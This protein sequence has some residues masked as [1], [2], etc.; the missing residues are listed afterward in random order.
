[1]N[2]T[3]KI[4]ISIL[5]FT[6]IYGQTVYEEILYENGQEIDTFA[7]QLPENFNPDNIYPLLIAFHQWGGNHL[8][9]F[10]TTFDE[11]ANSRNWIFMSPFGGSSNNYNH[12]EAQEMVKKAIEWLMDNYHIDKN[13]IYAVGGSMGGAS[14][15]IYANN[16]LNPNEPMIAATA[17]ASGIL[18]CERRAIEMDG[19]NSMTEWFGGNYDEVPFE[20]HRNSA[21]YFADST[22]SMHY[23]LKYIPLYFDFGITETH[24][25]HAEEMYQI[26]SGYNNNMWIDQEPTGSH[27]FSVFDEN[28]VCDWLSQFELIDNPDTIN[29]NLDQSSRAYWLEVNNEEQIENEFMRITASREIYQDSLVINIEQTYN[30]TN[31]N[32]TLHVMDNLYNYINLY[33]EGVSSNE[34]NSIGLTGELI[35]YVSHI[36]VNGCD[37]CITMEEDIIWVVINAENNLLTIHYPS[38][39]N[40]DGSWDILDILLTINFIMNQIEPTPEQNFLA[41]MNQDGIINILDI[42]SMVNL[43]LNQ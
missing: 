22:Q 3:I 28:H 27:G 6:Q 38:D 42:I 2:W 36:S 23:N 21:I 13:R 7:Y 29:V 4:L 20:Y 37:F 31:N 43:I 35:N 11:E 17:S 10:S 33:Y 5:V 1:M 15:M 8:S 39:I 19:N 41:D 34:Y 16:H 32:I 24:R 25:A 40:N 14:G 26:M 18:D 30:I 12:Q 9:T